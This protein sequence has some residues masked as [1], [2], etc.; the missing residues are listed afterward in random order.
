[1]LNRQY[2][3]FFLLRFFALFCILFL[4]YSLNAQISNFI[5]YSVENG[6][7]QSQVNAVMEDSRG[8]IWATTSGGGANYYDGNKFRYLDEKHGMPSNIV[9]LV[10]ED[11][12]GNMWFSTND[13][14]VCKYDGTSFKKFKEDNGLISN[15]IVGISRYK[16][17]IYAA[18]PN[19]INCIDGKS[20]SVLYRDIFSKSKII[21]LYRDRQ[22]RIWVIGEHE[23]FLMNGNNITNISRTH[24]IDFNIKSI[25]QDKKGVIWLGTEG[26]GLYTLKKGNKEDDFILEKFLNHP[27]LDNFDIKSMLFDSRNH[28]WVSTYGMGVIRYDFEKVH[29]FNRSTGFN[30]NAIL[31][32]CEDRFGNVWFGTDGAGLIRYMYSP[33]VFYNDQEGLNSAFIYSITNDSQDKFWVAAYAKGVFLYDKGNVK[34]FGKEQGLNSTFVR[35]LMRARNGKIYVGSIEGVNIIENEKVSKLKL[36]EEQLVIKCITEDKEGNIWFGSNGRGVWKYNG[37][38]FEWFHEGNGLSFNYVHSLFCDSKGRV[39]IGTGNGV[40]SYYNGKLQD[41]SLASGFCNSYIGSIAEDK[42]GNLY[43]GTDKCVTIFNGQTFK[44]IFESDGLSSGTIYLLQKDKNGNVW[45]GTNK[46]V[47]RLKVSQTGDLLSVRNYGLYE[48]FKGVECNSRASSTDSA[49]HMYFG[50]VKGLTRYNWEEDQGDVPKP[51]LQ[52]TDVRLF[53]QKTDW[54]KFDFDLT[55]WY[56]FP[57][58]PQLNYDQNSISFSFVG[59]DQYAP[60]KV[61]YLCRLEG[62]EE[63]WHEPEANYVTY[64]NLHAGKYVFKVKSFTDFE[65]NSS[66][67]SYEFVILKPFWKTAWFLILSV[68]TVVLLI[69]FILRYR[70]Y[71]TNLQRIRLENQVEIRTREI[72][73]QKREIETLIKEIHHRVKNNLQVINSILNLQSSYINDPQSKQVFKEC[74]SRIYSMSVIHERLYE[75]HSLSHLNLKDY[76]HKLTN[77]LREAYTVK[78]PVEFDLRINVDTCGLDT[79]IPFGLLL[80]ELISNSLKYAFTDNSKLNII[81]VQLDLTGPGQYCLIVGDNG[82]GHTK[83]LNEDQ[84]TFGMELIKVLVEQLNGIITRL[85]EDGAVY[86]IDFVNIDKALEKVP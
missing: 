56:H 66:E 13:G 14:G 29:Y 85:P 39:W 26:K 69:Y 33:F 5:Y 52:F 72:T 70:I 15:T 37:K 22:E 74:Q 59:I 28:L 18:S 64:T 43:F 84:P 1:M 48:G 42:F 47:D 54:T 2:S 9:Q 8:F 55:P 20:V 58:K 34:K 24:Q 7:S 61:R 41:Y 80:N 27:E 40:H 36:P 81:K 75:T 44:P 50:T 6:L 79:L 86:K 38:D 3:Y 73:R 71:K 60:E 76:V 63:D 78:Y 77:Y 10:E 16:G 11:D 17:R 45:A 12:E 68:V 49:G 35:C 82:I 30:S 65:S 53:S 57:M 4:S 21:S 32:M 67:I 46:G 19:G 31:S 83:D 23:L 62:F 25:T 51:V